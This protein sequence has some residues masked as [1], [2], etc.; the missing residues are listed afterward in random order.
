ME[1]S[2]SLCREPLETVDHLKNHLRVEHQVVKYRLD[3]VMALST[4]STPEEK[5]LV[6]EGRKRLA[7]RQ[8]SGLWQK[9]GNQFSGASQ[10]G[11]KIPEIEKESKGQGLAREIAEINKFLMDNSDESREEERDYAAPSRARNLR[12]E[13]KVHGVESKQCSQCDYKSPHSGTLKRHLKRHNGSNK[14]HMCSYS[15]SRANRFR[16]HLRTHSGENSNSGENSKKCSLCD[17]ATPHTGTF[18]RHF[19]AHSSDIKNGR[20]ACVKD[21]TILMCG[22]RE[23]VRR[24]GR[25]P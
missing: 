13:S 17:Y 6:E 2:C 25:L 14:C 9:E 3:L 22:A 23:N 20:Y 16:S 4:L 5:S 18:R 12:A 24:S 21:F 15:C 7:N 19:K 1:F 10:A 8:D 11:A